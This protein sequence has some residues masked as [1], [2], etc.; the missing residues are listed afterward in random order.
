MRT[1][2]ADRYFTE[3]GVLKSWPSRKSRDAQLYALARLSK[4]FEEGRQYNEREVNEVLKRNIAFEDF[5]LVR[6]ELIDL[7]LLRRTRDCGS[8]WRAELRATEP[9]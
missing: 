5:V 4:A 1:K 8:Y 3:E 6:R 7:G 9:A 2:T